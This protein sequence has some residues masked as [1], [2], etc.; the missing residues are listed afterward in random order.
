VYLV[1]IQ[2]SQ[3][4]Q[5]R[6][7]LVGGGND[8]L[9]RSL[10]NRRCAISSFV[11]PSATNHQFALAFGEQIQIG[12]SSG[13]ATLRRERLDEASDDAWREQRVPGRDGRPARRSSTGSVSL[14]RKPL[15]PARMA[16]RTYSS[17]SEVARMV[18]LTSRRRRDASTWSRRRLRCRRRLGNDVDDVVCIQECTK[19]IRTRTCRQPTRPG[20]RLDPMGIH[21]RTR[22]PWSVAGQ[23]RAGHRARRRVRACRSGRCRCRWC[24]CRARRSRRRSAQRTNRRR[25]LHFDAAREQSHHPQPSLLTSRSTPLP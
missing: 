11:N 8:K 5:T 4:G 10:T 18:T 9:G 12:R 24:H 1:G 14:T 16:S 20:S 22:N 13:F 23:R 3:P 2:S 21:A 7:V 19:T 25:T 17:S 6:P 15:A